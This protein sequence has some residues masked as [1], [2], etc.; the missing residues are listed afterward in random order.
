MDSKAPVPT[1]KIKPRD[2]EAIK[3]KDLQAACPYWVWVAKFT[4]ALL[5]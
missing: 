5:R 1:L 3:P 2:R 4:Q